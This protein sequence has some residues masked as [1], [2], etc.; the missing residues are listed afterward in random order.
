MFLNDLKNRL[1][2]H[3]VP[4]SV[5]NITNDVTTDQNISTADTSCFTTNLQADVYS[6]KAIS[7]ITSAQQRATNQRATHQ[8]RREPFFC[9]ERLPSSSAHKH[10]LS[11]S[12]L[13]ESR[14]N[15]DSKR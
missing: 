15:N 14:I 6:V 3:A 7:P 1:Q 11:T 12:T 13:L 5:L 2:P 8:V 10:S 9:V 4:S